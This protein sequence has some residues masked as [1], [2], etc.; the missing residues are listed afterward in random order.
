MLSE[1]K[2]QCLCPKA[3]V[4]LPFEGWLIR[5][6]C[7]GSL[8]GTALKWGCQASNT[9]PG[10]HLE[11]DCG[12]SLIVG[13]VRWLNPKRPQILNS[14]CPWELL[15][16][17]PSPAALL[18]VIAYEEVSA[19]RVS[20]MIRK[21]SYWVILVD[22]QARSPHSGASGAF[23]HQHSLLRKGTGTGQPQQRRSWV[24]SSS[25]RGSWLGKCLSVF[26]LAPYKSFCMSEYKKSCLKK[27]K[28]GA[29]DPFR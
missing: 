8:A 2:P 20:V 27:K 12:L 14:S 29:L 7:A 15:V 16:R 3:W 23:S 10:C 9:V 4:K 17:M 28:K 21:A 19:T 24:H 18:F 11:P 25:R 6:S 26:P 13:R 1:L 5:N 22:N